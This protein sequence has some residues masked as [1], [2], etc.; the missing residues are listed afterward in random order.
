MPSCLLYHGPG[1]RQAAL[2]KAVEVGRLVAPPFGDSGL[3]TS[4]AREIVGLLLSTPIGTRTGVVVVG[5]MDEANPKASDVLLKRIE[6]FPD[7]VQPILWAHDLGGVAPTIRSRCLAEWAPA[8][9]DDVGDDEM[10]S[11]ALDIVEAVKQG[12]L[13]TIP[14]MV[15]NHAKREY[16]LVK[17]L[18]DVL[19]MES[20]DRRIL[21]IWERLRRVLRWRNVTSVE[22]ISI[23]LGGDEP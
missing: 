16:D 7:T 5:P 14:D 1:A 13:H 23:L 4:E 18:A 11:A 10:M 3:K 6:E 19:S 2:S 8:A 9:D 15:R 21:A 22:I 17:A 20:E 12:E